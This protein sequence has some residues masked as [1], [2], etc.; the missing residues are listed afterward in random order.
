MK[1]TLLFVVLIGLWVVDASAQYPRVTIRQ[2]QQVSAESLLVADGLQNNKPARWTLQTAPLSAHTPR[3][4][5]DT[6]IITAV[7]VVPAKVLTFNQS[8]FTMLLADT[9]SAYP[10]GG[11]FARVNNAVDTN[12]AIT[13]GILNV[14]RGDIIQIYGWVAEFPTTNMNSLSQFNIV[15]GKPITIIGSQT[16]QTPVRKT[17]GDFYNGIFSGGTVRYSTGELYEG[18]YVELVNLQVNFRVN[19]T[20]GTFSAVDLSGNEITMYDASK[21]FTLGH[22][23]IVGPPDT[24][25]QR[26]YP[27][28]GTLI[29]TLRGFITTVSGSESPRGFRIAPVYRNDYVSR[30]IRLPTISQHRR[31]PIIVPSDSAGRISVRVTRQTA[32]VTLVELFYSINNGAFTALP[33]TLSDT[34]YKANIP[35]QAQNTFVKYFVKATDSLNNTIIL[36]N[37]ALSGAAADTSRGL[38]FYTVLNRPLTIQDVQTTPFKNGRSGYLGASVSLNGI[39]T[40]DT[41]NI[42]LAAAGA[43]PYYM[44][45]TNQPW[46]GIWF[47]DTLSALRLLRNGDSV[48]VTGTVGEQFDVTRIQAITTPPVVHSTNNTIPSPLVLTTGAFGPNVSNGAAS[49]EPYEGMLVRFNNVTVTDVAPIFSDPTEFEIDDGSGPILIRRDGTNTFSNVPADSILGRT[50][51]RVG[52]RIS[53][54]Q[55]LI[56]FAFNRYKIV[57]RRNTD[58]GTVTGVEIEHDPTVPAVYALD[59][60][61]P[62]PFN[63][64]TVIEYS[65]PN[66]KPVTLKIYN[67]IGQEVRTLVNQV[68][69]AGKYRVK[70]EGAS[71]ASGVYFYKLEAGEFSQV[72]KMLLLK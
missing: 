36:A 3:V 31:N 32:A 54:V 67:V 64:T 16:V 47:Y 62:N 29:D 35:Q 57:P 63:P 56:Y 72:K 50:I 60:N 8:G 43:L 41:A 17:V 13:D 21:F 52:N 9:G 65:L 1:R 19:T 68:Q 12:Q 18:L 58:Y 59:Q 7:C 51:L 5:N 4:T 70:F 45:M 22:G 2:I 34:T 46:S 28:V 48:T 69:A 44:Q 53:Y 71:V 27:Q 33:M 11:I 20:R 49:A 15:A 30:G 38:F 25:W 40:G 23:T 61:Y 24:T 37:S 39:V 55:G 66:Q 14:A 26:I 6:M 42:K 10:W